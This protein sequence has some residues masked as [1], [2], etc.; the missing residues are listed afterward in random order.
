MATATESTANFFETTFSTLRKSAESA[1]HLQ[2][3]LFKEWTKYWPGMTQSTMDWNAG[4]RKSQD[5]WAATIAEAMKQ[6]RELLD[7]QYRAGAAALEEAFQVAAAKDPE[8]FR[9][10]CEALCRQ[11]LTLVKESSEAQM[12]Q[13]QD[14]M[15]KWM[16]SCQMKQ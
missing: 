1:I 2:Q 5:E 16:D 10:R 15:K 8:E 4:V 9:T 6:H 12:R 14:A 13:F 3:Q 7:Q 11:T